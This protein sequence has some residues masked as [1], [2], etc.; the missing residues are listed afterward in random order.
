MHILSYCAFSLETHM[1]T[2]RDYY[3]IFSAQG[4]SLSVIYLF[5]TKENCR[6]MQES[7][8]DA[9]LSTT[10][11]VDDHRK[12]FQIILQFVKNNNNK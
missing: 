5:F 7:L 8:K 9:N 2:I 4:L 1:N 11:A 12:S 3:G 6:W 10:F